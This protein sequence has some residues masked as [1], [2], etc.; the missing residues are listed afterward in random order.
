VLHGLY[1]LTVNIAAHQPVLVAID[2]AH[3]ADAA[4]LR[5]L[6]YLVGRLEGLAV[7]VVVALR[8][9]EPANSEDTL[10]AIRA[11]GSVV[12]PLLLSADAVGTM[13]RTVLNAKVTDA[14]CAA[15][16]EASGGNPFYLSELLHSELQRRAD[17]DADAGQVPGYTS[18]VVFNYIEAR[19]RRLDRD[20]LG[21]AQA[22]AVLG[23]G[24]WLRACLIWSWRVSCSR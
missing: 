4:S 23:D 24:C 3:W 16:R 6:A 15:L 22:L 5:W 20:A 7:A 21:L 11:M 10:S 13:A 19:I 8:P 2:D 1:W 9:A 17:G 14:Q 12:R 18:E